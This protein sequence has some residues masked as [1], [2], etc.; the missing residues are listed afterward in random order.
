MASCPACERVNP[1]DAKYCSV[2]GSPLV[3]RC[4]ACGAIN[5]R[6]RSAC[7]HCRAALVPAP[8]PDAPEGPVLP[9][10][11]DDVALPELPAVDWSLS[12]RSDLDLPAPSE[13]DGPVTV[14]DPMPLV[15]DADA[16]RHPPPLPDRAAQKASRRARVRRAQLRQRLPADGVLA[17]DVLVLEAD[18]GARA[19]LCQWLETFGFRTH[20]AS[21]AAEAEALSLR[22]ANVAVFLG[23]GRDATAA[24]D[25][26]RRLR[27]RVRHRPQALIAIGDRDRHADRVRMELAGADAVLLRPVGRGDVARTLEACSVVLPRDPRRGATPAG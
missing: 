23:L 3:M 10:L 15:A 8:A 20:L 27:E 17:T 11:T 14:T 18:A 24:A 6:T 21:S 9:V 26:C 19:E 5:V 4:P 16:P 25:L 13:P 22:V 7:H 12:L 2:C 1:L